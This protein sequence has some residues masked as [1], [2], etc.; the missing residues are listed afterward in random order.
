MRSRIIVLLACLLAIAAAAVSAAEF[1][2][3][4]YSGAP[5]SK[6]LSRTGKVFVGSRMVRID[7]SAQ[8]QKM[9]TITRLDRK[10]FWMLDPAKKQYMEIPITRAALAD[11]ASD[12]ALLERCTKKNLG[13]EKVGGFVCEKALYTD[14]GGQG[15]KITRWFSKELNWPVKTQ[16]SMPDGK[17]MVQETRNVKMGKQ[18]ASLFEIPKGY[19]KQQ[20]PKQS[21]SA[22][23]GKKPR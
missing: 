13:K 5:G 19:K 17:S 18:A 8:G 6:E 23:S 20:P 11:P 7:A 4:V 12:A 15:V 21:Q 14:K 9:S 2:A 16:I 1:S 3:E 22:P 10:V